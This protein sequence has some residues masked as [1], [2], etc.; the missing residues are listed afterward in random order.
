MNLSSFSDDPRITLSV[1]IGASIL[2][3]CFIS[4]MFLYSYRMKMRGN[5]EQVKGRPPVDVEEGIAISTETKS[6]KRF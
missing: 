3:V 1:Y 6:G 5:T 2:F 4:Y